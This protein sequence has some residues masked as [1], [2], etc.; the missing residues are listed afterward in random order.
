MTLKNS[1]TVEFFVDKKKYSFQIESN[2]NDH[3]MEIAVES[4]LAR[5]HEYTANSFCAYVNSKTYMTD[6]VAEAK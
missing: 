6:Q 3:D 4:W 5:T 1:H 2:I